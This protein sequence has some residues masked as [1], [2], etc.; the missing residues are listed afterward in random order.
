MNNI[1][2]NIP[3]RLNYIEQLTSDLKSHL[4]SDNPDALAI[5]GVMIMQQFEELGYTEEEFRE[6]VQKLSKEHDQ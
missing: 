1:P 4:N 2:D 6:L 5:A 3:T